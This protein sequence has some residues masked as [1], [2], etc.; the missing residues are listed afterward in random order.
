MTETNLNQTWRERDWPI[1]TDVPVVAG[2]LPGMAIVPVLAARLEI[3]PAM[4][5][6]WVREKK[7]IA[8]PSGQSNQVV[9]GSDAGPPGAIAG[10]GGESSRL[11]LPPELM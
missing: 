4:A 3:T 10:V 6:R 7:R 1:A 2:E 9:D 11:D 8:W 5:Y